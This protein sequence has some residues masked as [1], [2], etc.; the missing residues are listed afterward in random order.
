MRFGGRI[1]ISQWQRK[2]VIYVALA[3]LSIVALLFILG[4]ISWLVGGETVRRLPGKERADALNAVRQTVLAAIG[5]AAVLGGLAFTS[6]TYHLSKR[7]QVT[8]RFSRAISLLAADS[9]EER[10]GAVY[11]LEHV[12][13]ESPQDHLTVVNLLANFIRNRTH[14]PGFP[15]NFSRPRSDGQS[16]PSFSVEPDADVE[17]ALRILAVRPSRPEPFRIDL[18]H[19]TLPG[20]H[21]RDFEFER[22]PSFRRVFFTWADLRRSDF[23]GV[24][25]SHAI[26][27]EADMRGS[28]LDKAKLDHALLA[29]VDLRGAHLG[30]SSLVGAFLD[31]ADLRDC[32]GLTAEQ[33]AS[34]YIDDSTKL[35]NRLETDEWVRARIAT[36]VASENHRPVPSPTA[37]PTGS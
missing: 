19:V 11:S 7:G 2:A 1:H 8:E 12:L 6:R 25:F 22:T 36:C 9:A 35:P 4:P 5:G 29:R 18:R 37:R 32:G 20:L 21:L 27:T 31:G 30:D 33:L 16:M 14:P 10:L 13:A 3:I 15:E 23:R 24:D 17:A 34:A 28:R 26:F